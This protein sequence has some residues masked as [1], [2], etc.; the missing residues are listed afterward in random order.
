MD[1]SA[2]IKSPLALQPAIDP[3]KI[4]RRRRPRPLG[5][6]QTEM[7]ERLLHRPGRRIH[8]ISEPHHPGEAKEKENE[9]VP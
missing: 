9:D 7:I 1:G 3:N 4:I 6:S 5:L 8:I 2:P